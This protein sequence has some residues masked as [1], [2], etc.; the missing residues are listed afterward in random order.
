[1]FTSDKVINH[2]KE[3]INGLDHQGR[4]NLVRGIAHMIAVDLQEEQSDL[5]FAK[6]GNNIWNYARAEIM[7]S[8]AGCMMKQDGFKECFNAFMLSQKTD[9][10]KGGEIVS[11]SLRKK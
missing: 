6:K 1:M 3:N 4:F 7:K 10:S 8:D 2:Y 5:I 11:D 9:P